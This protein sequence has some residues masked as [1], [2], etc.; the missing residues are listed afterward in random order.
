MTV[1]VDEHGAGSPERS[2]QGD[3]DWLCPTPRSLKSGSSRASPCPSRAASSN[4]IKDLKSLLERAAS[5]KHSAESL[6]EVLASYEDQVVQVHEELLRV[7]KKMQRERRQYS[8]R[9]LEKD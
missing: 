4:V 9:V 7:T 2:H 1:P 3:Q 6:Q 8:L 5:T